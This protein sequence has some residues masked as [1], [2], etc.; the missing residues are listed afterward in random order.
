MNIYGFDKT[1]LLNYPGHV[2]ATIFTGGCNMRCPFCHNGELV[3]NPPADMRISEEEILA[4]LK[5]RSS[6]LSGLCITGGEPT[7]QP[8]LVDFIAK[9]RALGYKIKLDTNGLKPDT[10]SELIDAGMLDYVAM[11]I[12]AGRDNYGR[13][14]GIDTD[15]DK[16][17]ESVR[18]LH[19]SDIEFELRTTVVKG[20]HTKEDF[21]DIRSWL[22]EII[23]ESGTG[24]SIKH[25]YLQSYVYRDTVLDK[26][27]AFDSFS[28]EELERFAG[29]LSTVV[30]EVVL[31]GIE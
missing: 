13:A 7:L 12:K 24:S 19:K 25:Y 16:I 18:I 2:A 29:I 11:D 26:E 21:T 31:R 4:H 1:S 20:I 9:V 15:I 6:V 5:K 14:T 23:N 22:A 10:L 17:S 3:L 30:N 28:K 8:D 27:R